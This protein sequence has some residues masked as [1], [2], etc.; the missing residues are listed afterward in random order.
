MDKIGAWFEAFIL[1]NWQLIGITI[2]VFMG[3]CIAEFISFRRNQGKLHQI[4][5]SIQYLTKELQGG[6]RK[7]PQP[8]PGS[9]TEQHYHWVRRYINGTERNQYFICQGT[10]GNASRITLLSYPP[11]LTT[12]SRS[13]LTVVPTVLTALGILGTF[14]GITQGMQGVEIDANNIAASLDSTLSLLDG[15]GTA[16]ATSLAGLSCSLLFSLIITASNY[17]RRRYCYALRDRLGNIAALKPPAQSSQEIYGAVESIP[18]RLEETLNT[19]M[20]SVPERLGKAINLDPMQTAAQDMQKVARILAKFS[21]NLETQLS[22]E[23]I[24]QAVGQQI[25]VVFEDLLAT[26]LKP[27]FVQIEESQRR[28]EALNADQRSVLGDL[29]GNMRTELIEPV[30]TRLDKSAAMTEKASQAVEKLHDEL[31]DLTTSLANSIATLTKTVETIETFQTRTLE[32]LQRFTQHLESTLTEFQTNTKDVLQETANEIRSGTI[33][34]LKQ[35]EITFQ[36]QSAMLTAIGQEASGLM[37]SARTELVASLQTI[38]QRLQAMSEATQAQLEAFRLAYQENLQR[39]F[40]QQNNLLEGTLGQQRDGLAAVVERLDRVFQEEYARRMEL[41]QALD[42]QRKRIAKT[43]RDVNTLVATSET[44]YTQ[45]R[46]DLLQTLGDR[47]AESDR[48]LHGITQQNQQMRAEWTQELNQYVQNL[49]QER[50][51]F[52]NEADTAMAQVSGKLL[53]TA[54]L[55]ANLLPQISTRSNGAN[56]DS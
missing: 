50:G 29:I 27:V 20:E 13:H 37:T 51:K 18:K 34:V 1:S 24:S 52:F 9:P 47:L 39:F 23:Q 16:F 10:A 7:I 40:E 44:L 5:R 32:Q 48:L 28:L 33:E 53:D 3:S 17:Q 30:A 25:G 22:S 26:H 45:N 41:N 2:G 54:N 56:P 35:A 11:E 43:L 8:Q 55:I 19:V 42:D 49:A 6:N 38:D 46:L 4:D 15:M 36:G 14:W 21:K 12:I 31:G